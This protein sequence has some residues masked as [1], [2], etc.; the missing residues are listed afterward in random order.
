MPICAR[1]QQRSA[2]RGSD[3]ELV[4]GLETQVKANLSKIGKSPLRGL[5]RTQTGTAGGK[6]CLQDSEEQKQ[7]MVNESS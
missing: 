5:S 1:C 4:A 6:C 2:V 7:T 3:G